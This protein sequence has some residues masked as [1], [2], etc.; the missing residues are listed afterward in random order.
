MKSIKN[1][2]VV[3]ALFSLTLGGCNKKS[4]QSE[5]ISDSESSIQNDDAKIRE[6]YN[7][8]LASGGTLS[9]EEWLA[10]IKGEKGDKG[11][12][13]EK[14]DKGDAGSQGQSGADGTSVLTGNSAPSNDLGNDG[15]SYIDLNTWNFYVKENGAWILK[16][17][18][19][20]RDGTSGGGQQPQS[21]NPQGLYFY[22]TDENTY[23]V[24]Q[25]LS[26]LL[27]NIVIPETYNG[28]PVTGIMDNGFRDSHAVSITIPNS[29]TAIGE[30]A[31]FGCSSLKSISIPN[32]IISL[33]SACFVG[34]NSL[35]YNEYNNACYLGNNTNPCVVLMKAVDTSI[36]SC[37]ISNNCRAIYD[38]AFSNCASLTSGS[39]T[40]PDTVTSIGGSAFSG[41]S[42]AYINIKVSSVEN[43]LKM[44]SK[45]SLGLYIRLLDSNNELISDVAIPE[46]ITSI[47]EDA[48]YGCY[49]LT[50]IAIPNSV[51]S[52]GNN[53]FDCCFKLKS[54]FIPKGVKYIS[55]DMFDDTQCLETIVIDEDNQ[56]YKSIDGIVYDKDVRNIILCPESHAAAISIPSSVMWIGDYAFELC[57]RI[58]SIFIP[59][60]VESIG[61]YAFK[62]C[63]LLGTIFIPTSVYSIGSYAFD[64]CY[65]LSLAFYQG[66]M[67]QWNAI[68]VDTGNNLFDNILI[69]SNSEVTSFSYVETERYAY[70]LTSDNRIIDFVMLDRTITSFDFAS[71]FPECSVLSLGYCAFFDCDSLTS[72]TIPNSVYVIGIFAFND[73][74][75]LTSVIIPISVMFVGNFAFDYDVTLFILVAGWVTNWHSR[76]GGI[77]CYYSD[78][79]N[80]DGNHWHYVDDVPTIWEE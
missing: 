79:P 76:C 47:P 4:S 54:I 53:A 49:S 12:K 26:T 77:K 18:I 27:S 62:E 65:S 39:V 80:Y 70:S 14:G 32:D 38:S 25:G 67:T 15:D 57:K 31:F 71:E 46:G 56:N 68:S 60:G 50:S 22:L 44:S 43:F 29:V 37:V 72:I 63:S 7:L 78:T 52:I 3:L 1:L 28:L 33:G 64:N 10:T 48:F 21:D 55:E 74:G 16:G 6:I 23:Y 2:F 73:C 34:C 59:K 13:G 9:Y 19:K 66:S 20:G 11:D 51:T 58:R 41:T 36:T 5:P 8:Y 45:R 17:N 24:G 42:L 61:S 35:D 75:S 30:E 40:I 69:E